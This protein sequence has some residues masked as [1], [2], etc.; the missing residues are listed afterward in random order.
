MMNVQYLEKLAHLAI[1]K[2]VN[3]QPNQPLNI[4]ACGDPQHQMLVD[5]CILE[6][7]KLGCPKVT[8]DIRDTNEERMLFQP[9]NK[10]LLDQRIET[11]A[12][13]YEEAAA[14]GAA[15]LSIVGEDPN[16]FEDVDPKVIVDRNLRLNKLSPN[17]RKGLDTGLLSWSIIAA[18]SAGWAKKV[19]PDLTKEQAIDA[20]WAD[21][22]TI[23][24]I[25]DRDPK[26]NWNQHGQMLKARMNKLNALG[27]VRF[28][29]L[30][31]NGTDLWIDLPEHAIFVGGST[32][33]QNGLEIFCNIPTEELF[34][35]PLKT[36]V[37]GQLEAMMPLNYN[38][39]IIDEFG[40]T[41]KEGKVVDFHAKKG[42]DVL[43][44]MLKSCK[45][46]DYLG[47]IALV[48]KSSPIRMA[49]RIFYN[50]LFDENAACHFALGQSYA[51][52]VPGSE[53]WDEEQQE[54]HGLNQAQIHVDFMVGADD[55]LIEGYQPDG[56]K[57][58]VFE[59]GSFTSEFDA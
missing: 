47:E 50:T 40:F 16:A 52:C 48:D 2:G 38:G 29:Y 31:K 41:F 28:H 35:V 1:V 32:T 10:A 51:E 57:I 45:N 43:E 27:L 58:I 49:N 36:G 11:L 24:R 13:Q 15:F 8:L 53:N 59:N 19:Y 39:Q 21:I 34:S 6:A 18:P 4:R 33:L 25:D 23:S 7:K 30:S 56:T 12:K 54:E 5:L 26:D 55:L 9:E 3:L 42:K 22:F 37:N 44:A 17:F 14:K 20:L 46:A